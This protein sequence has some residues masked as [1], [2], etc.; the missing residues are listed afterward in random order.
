MLGWA[1]GFFLAAIVAALFG[2]GAIASTFSAIALVL[3]WVFVGLFVISLL[4][5]FMHGGAGH[6]TGG[7]TGGRTVML[8]AIAAAVGML[9]YAWIDNDWTAQDVGR[10]IDQNASQITAELSDAG[11]RAENV[12]ENT[13]EELRDNTADALDEAEDNVSDEPRD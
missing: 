8:V 7:G 6:A 5:S 4:L 2:F 9:A 13:G 3:F 10:E 12:I 11:D 1:I